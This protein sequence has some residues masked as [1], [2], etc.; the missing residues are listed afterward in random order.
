MMRGRA[1]SSPRRSR[2]ASHEDR[3]RPLWRDAPP[4]L[5]EPCLRLVVV[6]GVQDHRFGGPTCARPGRAVSRLSVL[7]QVGRALTK[8]TGLAQT[9][10]VDQGA[11]IAGQ[12]RSDPRRQLAEYQSW[13]YSAATVRARATAA[14][15]LRLLAGEDE[16]TNHIFLDVWQRPSELYSGFAFRQVSL[17]HVLLAGNAYWFV[18][19]N[20]LGA[21]AG[22]YPL[23]PSHVKVIP[24]TSRFVD[25]YLLRLGSGTEVRLDAAEVIHLKAPNPISPY[26]GI[27]VV[28]AAS[29][30]IDISNYI[31]DYAM[32]A[33]RNHSVPAAWIKLSS[34]TPA[35][36]RKRIVH[37]IESS[38]R[39]VA[40]GNRT[41]IS[42]DAIESITPLTTSMAEVA[43][44]Q[45]AEFARDE[46]FA[47]FGVHRSMVGMTDQINLANAQAGEYSFAK[48]VVAADVQL[49]AD[50]LN[51]DLLPRYDPRLRVEFDNPV[52]DD[53]A[54][55]GNNAQIAWA[56]GGITRDEF[57]R[58][59][60]FDAAPDA[61]DGSVFEI[62]FNVQLVPAG[63]GQPPAGGGGA[64]PAGGPPPGGGKQ[65]SLEAKRSSSRG[66]AE[67]YIRPIAAKLTV[68]MTRYFDAQRRRAEGRL[69]N[70]HRAVKQPEVIDDEQE[71]RR[72]RDLLL[73]FLVGAATAALRYLRAR[74]GVEI[75]GADGELPP[76]VASLTHAR[77]SDAAAIITATTSAQLAQAIADARAAGADIG[78]LLTDVGAVFL[79]A[80]SARAPL[81]GRQET[82]NVFHQSMRLGMRRGGWSYK[83]WVT[84]GDDAVEEVCLQ[85]E[86]DGVIAID[87]LFS[88]GDLEPPTEEHPNCL[89]GGSVVWGPEVAA[90][91]E[92]W[93]EGEIV[94]LRTAAGHFLSVTPNH[95]ILTT[96]GWVL[97]G[98]LQEGD[99]VLAGSGQEGVAS[100]LDPDE[101][102][103]PASIEEIAR[104]FG[105]TRG[106][107]A[108]AMPTAPHDF[109][110][111]G[112]GSDVH[113]VR[114][115]RLL[116]DDL[117]SH[118]AQP[119]GQDVLGLGSARESALF[120]ARSVDQ[121][122]LA[123][124]GASPSLLRGP[125]GSSILL[126]RS[127][128]HEKLVRFGETANVDARMLQ[129]AVD[130]YAGYAVPSRESL[131]RFAGLVQPDE[132]L[133]VRR[134]PWAGHV[135]NL[136]STTGFYVGESIIVHNC[137]C[138][139]LPLTAEE[140]GAAVA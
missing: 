107:A 78:Q 32:A 113:V 120:P 36:E 90:T 123:C 111:D 25:G 57:R 53:Q 139:L 92:R 16:V 52:P 18:V 51:G 5:R 108:R 79:R 45:G 75:P 22:L 125:R 115:D 89:V 42:G 20:A 118:V 9:V 72:L 39:G 81:V 131:L 88:T 116:L 114:A 62:P 67:P 49:F 83:A 30:G 58:E 76:D 105:R 7:E 55:K 41:L 54:R 124:A 80:A 21:P 93:Y 40:A 48:W 133:K 138:V 10:S 15:G 103:V 26:Y 6:R 74:S 106:V 91:F 70:E 112:T 140:A 86:S 87:E 122:V 44:L 109:H 28:E 43:Y 84:A 46:I 97:A 73:P 121:F 12:T 119:G 85:A 47:L 101:A 33:F 68:E 1:S 31:H 17:L 130:R 65:K 34:D 24:G 66:S 126:G 69:R 110:G 128:S 137:R 98:M 136:Q 82:S 13:V 95:P 96:G 8:A 63:E 3:L 50:A 117:F 27:S 134:R 135:Y 37:M 102:Q 38:F 132:L 129:D 61:G 4:A 59:L 100:R 104:S 35:G 71:Q 127:A 14:V 99:Y 23:P 94:E 29:R 60:G 56:T 11:Q 19:P 64:T 2:A 77:A